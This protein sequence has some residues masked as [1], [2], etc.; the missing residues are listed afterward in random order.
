MLLLIIIVTHI[1]VCVQIIIA[2]HIDMSGFQVEPLAIMHM[3][4]ICISI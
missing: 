1:R 2:P 3:M 4:L